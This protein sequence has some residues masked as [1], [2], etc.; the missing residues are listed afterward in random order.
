[1]KRIILIAL[2]LIT[3]LCFAQNMQNPTEASSGQNT[4]NPEK[5][6]NELST[7]VSQPYDE[8]KRINYKDFQK[9]S[10]NIGQLMRR[11][12]TPEVFFKFDKDKFGRIEIYSFFQYILSQEQSF[13]A[14]TLL[15]LKLYHRQ[16]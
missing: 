7:S 4:I 2:F 8:T 5:V 15:V 10:K 16:S 12:F 14:D 6:L 9:V 11:F 1:M 3:E 13:P